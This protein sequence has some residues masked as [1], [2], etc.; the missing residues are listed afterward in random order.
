VKITKK[1]LR[2]IIKNSYL[3]E[4]FFDSISNLFKSEETKELEKAEL[5]KQNMDHDK[6][7]IRDHFK[8]FNV[9]AKLYDVH[10]DWHPNDVFV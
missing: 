8:E 5:R 10:Q 7:L 1:Q 2:Q 6:Q 4:G 3:N 9:I